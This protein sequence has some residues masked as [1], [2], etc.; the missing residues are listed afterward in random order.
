MTA[1]SLKQREPDEERD[2]RTRE[3]GNR[4]RPV[5]RPALRARACCCSL[6]TLASI[7]PSQRR[8]CYTLRSVTSIARSASLDR[9]EDGRLDELGALDLGADLGLGRGRVQLHELRDVELRLLEELDLRREGVPG[10]RGTRPR[11]RVE[12]KGRGGDEVTAVAGGTRS[13][14]VCSALC[15][16]RTERRRPAKG[17]EEQASR[18]RGRGRTA[19]ADGGRASQLRF[20]ATSDKRESEQAREEGRD[21][22]IQHLGRERDD[23]EGNERTLRTKMRW[24][25]WISCDAGSKLAALDLEVSSCRG[26]ARLRRARTRKARSALAQTGRT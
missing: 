22:E 17:E 18:G 15:V 14:G 3:R 11:R 6:C 4:V 2:E 25:G 23:E 7:M 9:L 13:P 20:T 12:S 10:G 24:S 1:E 16:S 5:G 21:E 8:D 19:C 26:S